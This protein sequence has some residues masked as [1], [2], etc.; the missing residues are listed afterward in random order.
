[1]QALEHLDNATSAIDSVKFKAT[2]S[3]DE[4]FIAAYNRALVHFRLGNDR[5]LADI[6]GLLHCALSIACT[7][8]IG[9]GAEKNG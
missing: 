1:M 5:G 4:D 9:S 3:E 2:Y 7:G 6:K 8:G